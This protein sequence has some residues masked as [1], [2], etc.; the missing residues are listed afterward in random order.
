[1]DP[2]SR[3]VHV[4]T[5]AEQLVTRDRVKES[6]LIPGLSPIVGDFFRQLT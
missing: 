5:A 2:V 3:A 4:I 6:P 1:V